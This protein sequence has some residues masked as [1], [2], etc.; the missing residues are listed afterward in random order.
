MGEGR[1][2]RGKRRNTETSVWVDKLHIIERFLTDK[3][4]LKFVQLIAR[5]IVY[6]W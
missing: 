2:E 4:E 5:S 3:S 6:I 1:G